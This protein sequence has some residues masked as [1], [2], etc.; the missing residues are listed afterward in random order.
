LGGSTINLI[1]LGAPLI[2]FGLGAWLQDV[3]GEWS[4]SALLAYGAV[5]VAFLCGHAMQS[6][7]GSS[8]LLIGLPLAFL[9]LLLGGANGLFLL[10]V[11]FAAGCVL[12]LAGLSPSLPWIVCALGA[13]L[14][15]AAGIRMLS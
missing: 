6:D 3:A 12:G 9:A 15:I 11:L 5:T 4:Q 2:V 1:V 10:G 8:W 7:N 14:S 13:L